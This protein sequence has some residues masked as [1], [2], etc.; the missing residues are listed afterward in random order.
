MSESIGAPRFHKPEEIP[1]VTMP[2]SGDDAQLA[3]YIAIYVRAL[4]A[5]IQGGSEQGLLNIKAICSY[6]P[7]IVDDIGQLTDKSLIDSYTQ[8]ILD[9]LNTRVDGDTLY[10]LA[11][12][13]NYITLLNHTSDLKHILSDS[14]SDKSWSSWLK[15]SAIASRFTPQPIPA[16]LTNVI[17]DLQNLLSKYGSTFQK[18]DE[19]QLVKA[20]FADLQTIFHS[21]Y[22][23]NDGYCQFLFTSLSLS[24]DLDDQTSLTGISPESLLGLQ[25][26]YFNA[27]TRDQQQHFIDMME[28]TL[29]SNIHGSSFYNDLL[30]YFLSNEPKSVS[31]PRAKKIIQDKKV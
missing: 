14:S 29:G 18:A 28:T 23:Y 16:D 26:A 15:K 1:P 24:G 11:K 7:T 6:I 3:T 13:E 5:Q 20:M 12:H 27:T 31:T 10:Q 2:K 25:D 21:L 22:R 9:K 30:V 19:D 17:R 8:S 4:Y